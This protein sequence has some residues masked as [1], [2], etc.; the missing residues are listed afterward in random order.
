MVDPVD[1]TYHRQLNRQLTV[2]EPRHRLV[3]DVCDG[4]R[5]TIHQAYRDGLEDLLTELLGSEPTRPRR[6]T[7]GDENGPQPG[8]AAAEAAPTSPS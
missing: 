7:H 3:R 5:G 8:Q 2:Q 6:S 1:D 4:T